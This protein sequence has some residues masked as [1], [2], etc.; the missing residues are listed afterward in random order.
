[1][2]ISQARIKGGGSNKSYNILD[3]KVVSWI[4]SQGPR[5]FTHILKLGSTTGISNELLIGKSLKE[6]SNSLCDPPC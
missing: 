2:C 4:E 6:T 1:M 5:N 3:P